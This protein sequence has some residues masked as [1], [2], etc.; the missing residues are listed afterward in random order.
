VAGLQRCIISN[1]YS[2]RKASTGLIFAA[3][4]AGYIP[5]IIPTKVVNPTAIKIDWKNTIATT[6]LNFDWSIRVLTAPFHF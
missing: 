2:Y 1:N 6:S 5:K 4:I 3:F